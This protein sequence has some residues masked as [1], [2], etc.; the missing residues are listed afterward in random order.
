M[1]ERRSFL[2]GLAAMF[3]AP[4]I[5]RAASLM[6]VRGV[7]L[8]NPEA[9]LD[10]L[11]ARMVDTQTVLARAIEASVFGQSFATY[12]VTPAHEFEIRQYAAEIIFAKEP[13]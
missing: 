12:E 3:A 7:P 2:T 5:V 1:L 11:V 8:A 6:P 9:M 13:S 4:A 10:L